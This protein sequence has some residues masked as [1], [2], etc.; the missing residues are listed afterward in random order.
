MQND[1]NVA[2]HHYTKCEVLDIAAVLQNLY[3]SITRMLSVLGGVSQQDGVASLRCFSFCGVSPM[4]LP[5]WMARRDI[6]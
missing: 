3:A 4:L 5:T 6:I 2:A 1:G